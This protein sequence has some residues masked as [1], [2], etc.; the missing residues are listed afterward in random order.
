MPTLSRPGP[1]TEKTVA[2]ALAVKQWMTSMP[3]SIGKDQPLAVAH[4]LMRD[5][6][7]RHLPVL[8]NGK[9]VG[10]LSE[11]DLFYLESVPGV[12]PERETVEQGMTQDVYC[13][14]PEA[15]L[16]DVVAEMAKHRYGSAVIVDRA[17]VVGVFTTTNAL[18]LLATF[19]GAGA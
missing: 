19:L 16:R 12:D 5:N 17:K 3:H 11:R 10:M 7:L 1:D 8:E 13:V 18:E 15:R 6:A 9:L 14:T 4:R 2:P